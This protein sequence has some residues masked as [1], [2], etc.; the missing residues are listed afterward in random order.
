MLKRILFGERSEVDQKVPLDE[1]VRTTL[2]LQAI[3]GVAL[4]FDA[5][6]HTHLS[7]LRIFIGATKTFEYKTT[8][9]SYQT[10]KKPSLPRS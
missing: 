10:S 7:L 5:L 6:G 9:F 3:F 8:H 4:S 1:Q 2:D